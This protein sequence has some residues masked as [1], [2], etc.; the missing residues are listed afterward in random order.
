MLKEKEG[1]GGIH[2]EV[3]LVPEEWRATGLWVED[4]HSEGSSLPIDSRD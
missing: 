3:F 4:T 2:W 1:E